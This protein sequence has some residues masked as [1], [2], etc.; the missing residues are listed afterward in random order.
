[1]GLLYLLFSYH[2]FVSFSRLSRT[3]VILNSHVT[4]LINTYGYR[5]LNSAASAI[6]VLL[7][8]M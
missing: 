8:Q 6:R 2:V 5:I 7:Q 3:N 1:M 4:D